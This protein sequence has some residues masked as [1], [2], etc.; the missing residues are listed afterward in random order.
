MSPIK[1]MTTG[2]AT[3][4]TTDTAMGSAGHVPIMTATGR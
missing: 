2:M 4:M 3:A 1:G